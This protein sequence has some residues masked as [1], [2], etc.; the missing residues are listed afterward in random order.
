MPSPAPHVPKARLTP[1]Q[2]AF[3]NFP[4]RGQCDKP[5]TVYQE[6]TVGGFS[7]GK[8][9]S[10]LQKMLYLI[11]KYPGNEVLFGRLRG[12]DLEKTMIPEFF[13]QCPESWIAKVHKRGQTGMV[14]HFKNKSIAYFQHIRDASALG[15]KTRR[16][17]HN[18][19]AF[20]V[21]QAEEIS[22]EE[23]VA[24]NGRLRNNCAKVRFALGNAN[25]AGNDWI[26]QDFFPNYKPL[27]PLNGVFYRSYVN[28]NKLGIHMDSRENMISNG[29]FVDDGF[30]E[31]FILNSPPEFVRRYIEAS[32]E[33]FSGKVYKE[34]TL[35]SVHNI[36]PLPH[37]PD[38]WE[39]VGPIDVGGSCPWSVLCVYVDNHGNLI[40]TDEFT[41]ATT[42]VDEV[43]AWIK[44]SMP[45]DSSKTTF[46]IDPENK[47]AA[48][49]LA[50]HEIYTRVAEKHVLA[51]TLSVAGYLHL[52][53]GKNGKGLP[54]PEWLR[55]A[56]PE[57][58]KRI[59]LEGCP[60]VFVYRTCE[61]FRAEHDGALWVEGRNEIKKTATARFDSVDSFRYAVATRPD[62]AK[63]AEKDKYAELR[64]V[65]PIS[66]QEAEE[67]A[68]LI[69]AFKAR[70]RGNATAEMFLDGTEFARTDAGL[71]VPA[72]MNK[73]DWN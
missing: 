69:A 36:N 22:R 33:N 29:G 40:V 4:Q 67:D 25:P 17:G 70:Q 34:F 44:R 35:N 14:V 5:Y 37:I 68:A 61:T 9:F 20:L 53:K 73:W 27:D 26:F 31:N 62:P 12:S 11:A 16:T 19:G 30:Y 3:I 24:L 66:A 8:S 7:S 43:A 41:K 45:W 63:L 57:H 55:E 1:S 6:M 13:K 38:S 50:L 10:G 71:F 48:T 46:V 64:A 18:L 15:T 65:S 52:R 60:R 39:C 54:A 21:E 28:G 58:A 2:R 42:L 23:W 51:G 56:D 49:D 47:V 72:Q 32:F 59:E